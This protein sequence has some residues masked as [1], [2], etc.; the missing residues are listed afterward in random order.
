[1]A[2]LAF[3]GA[4]RLRAH[5]AERPDAPA[6]RIPSAHYT[7][8]KPVWDTVTF[9]ELDRRSDAYARG[10]RAHGVRPGDRT[11]M[12]FKPSADYFAVSFGLSKLGAVPVLLDPR[13]GLRRL[14]R[15]IEQAAPRVV[16]GL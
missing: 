10:L 12:L 5:A 11:L 8:D 9:A 4:S 6:L 2:P 13:M 1:M 3:N 14:L 16:I 7:A 15:C